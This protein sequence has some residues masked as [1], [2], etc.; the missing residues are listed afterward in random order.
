MRWLDGITD[1]MDMSLSELQ[2]TVKDREDRHAAVHGITKC[3]TQLSDST[4]TTN[5]KDAIIFLHK[6]TFTSIHDKW[7]LLLNLWGLSTCTLGEECLIK[8]AGGDINCVINECEYHEY[9][10]LLKL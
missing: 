10:V 2:E 9:T 8:Q 6:T 5:H 4:T 1:S 3:R 7:L